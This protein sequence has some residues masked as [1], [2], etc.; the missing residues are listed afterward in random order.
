[1]TV[2]ETP[3]VNTIGD[4][5]R[6]LWP[7]LG[8]EAELSR[9]HERSDALVSEV[10]I[11]AAVFED[12]KSS[13]KLLHRSNL[14]LMAARSRTELA[15]NL[16]RRREDVDWNALIEQ[17]C[18]LAIERWRDGDPTID[19]RDVDFT[20]RPRWFIK[21]YLEYGGP[22]V[23]FGPG[24]TSKS[25]F[26]LAMA[27]TVASGR[28][29]VGRLQG[30][31]GPVLYLDWE[32]DEYTHAERLRGICSG[33]GT[34]GVPPIFYRHMLG[35]LSESLPI[36]QREIARLGVI[37]TVVDSLAAARGAEPESA[38][39][40]NKLFTGIRALCVPA[41]CIDHVS[42]AAMREAGDGR[43]SPFGSIFCENRAR[44]TWSLRRAGDENSDE[45]AVAFVH[46]KTN[47]G[48]Y[49]KGHAFHL[50][51][52]NVTTDREEE[53]LQSL[54]IRSCDLADV[55]ELE[56]SQPLHERIT[57]YLARQS[58][59]AATAEAVADALLVDLKTVRARMSQL[60][61]KGTLISLADHRYGLG[62]A[63]RA[64]S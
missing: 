54:T 38:E 50:R 32:T 33:V 45:F 23:L 22:T 61:S 51:F 14:N 53:R 59:A 34:A 39:V 4:A 57:S 26:A 27:V 21:P 55:P 20:Q 8:L 60:K 11:A 35:S 13:R 2:I 24:G 16:L 44:N 63:G 18:F 6:F 29:V 25:F 56:S 52:S 49:Q 28:P 7:T 30:P 36:V 9:F 12:G 43:L 41:L 46:Q 31:P 48:R 5:Y 64:A 19:L 40:T 37:M 10:L 62:A 42:K 15:N 17:F 47:N 58:E 1:M 3:K